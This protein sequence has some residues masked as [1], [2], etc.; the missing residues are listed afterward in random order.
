VVFQVVHPELPGEFPSL[1]SLDAFPGNLPVQ[2]TSFIG[3]DAE[4]TELEKALGTA[5]LV[6]L[7]VVGGVGK[8]RL[9]LQPGKRLV[10]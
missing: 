9:A 7:T 10:C 5:R 1:R 6:T 2:L 8:T 3:R 4:M